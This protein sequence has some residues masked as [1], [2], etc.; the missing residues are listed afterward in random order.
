MLL[1]GG[2]G[3]LHLRATNG[4][5]QHVL[6]NPVHVVFWRVRRL[7]FALLVLLLRILLIGG[8]PWWYTT[9]KLLLVVYLAT[10]SAAAMLFLEPAWLAAPLAQD[11]V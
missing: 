6:R 2:N 4:F 10:Q 8:I 1:A 9:Q 7:A 11:L 5:D 3:L